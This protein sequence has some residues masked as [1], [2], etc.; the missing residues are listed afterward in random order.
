[1]KMKY[2]ALALLA[3]GM[4]T[5]CSSDDNLS[6]GTGPSTGDGPVAYLAVNLKSSTELTRADYEN[7][8][9]E[10][11]NISNIRFYFYDTSGNPCNC[12][13]PKEGGTAQ[14][15]L[16][17][18]N[19]TMTEQTDGGNVEEISNAILVIDNY[20]GAP[21]A[22]MVAVINHKPATNP[23]SLSALKTAIADYSAH[24]S[25]KFIMSNSTVSST[26]C[27]TNLTA[28]NFFTTSELAQ[29]NPVEV[30]VERVV[31]KVQ[32]DMSKITNTRKSVSDKT[33]Y[34]IDGTDGDDAATYI[35]IKGWALADYAQKSYLCK[36][37]TAS[38]TD[39]GFTLAGDHRSFW[40]NSVAFG[41]DHSKGNQA[42]NAIT[43]STGTA[44]YT[45]E[46]TPTTAISDTRSNSLTK[47]IIAAKLVDKSGN[48]KPRYEL[49]GHDYA[50]ADD[51][52]TLLANA[53]NSYYIKTGSSGSGDTYTTISKDQL[54]LK[55]LTNG[56]GYQ[57]C[58]QVKMDATTTSNINGAVDGKL[59]KKS[60]ETYTEVP[61]GV[62]TL[63]GSLAGSGYAVRAWTDGMTYY[64]AT[65]PHLATNT[66][67]NTYLGAYGIVRN[68]VYKMSITQFAGF[69]TPVFDGT[70]TIVPVTP[71]EENTFLAATLNILAWNIVSKD[72]V[73]Q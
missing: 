28:A 23:A 72:V 30:F 43:T 42:W 40:A 14:N 11:N 4:M 25:G 15:Y 68:H 67:Q 57:A 64:Y 59:Y 69:G 12:I 6:G 2:W 70:T 62:N 35:D 5:A 66:D 31:A 34:L 54:E 10:E 53:F 61:N 52:L 33:I 55:A 20:D 60:G 41:T 27:E 56:N 16:D 37:L 48:V 38:Y 29:A 73:M 22:K 65:I 8:S 3:G 13:T 63:N 21:P 7:G 71:P 24:E 39:L 36:Q 50:S 45:Q 26:E 32:L 18:T 47:I 46:N 19:V 58:A 51:V 44:L 1:M 17:V 9:D 49:A